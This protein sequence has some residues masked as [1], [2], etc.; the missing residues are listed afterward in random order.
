MVSIQ[1]PERSASPDEDG[2][3][4]IKDKRETIVMI[5]E[6]NVIIAPDTVMTAYRKE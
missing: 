6:V 2:E 1:L 3:H 5:L 4:A